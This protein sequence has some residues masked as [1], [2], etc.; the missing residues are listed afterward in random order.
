[1]TKCFDSSNL[2]P[3]PKYEHR[4]EYKIMMCLFLRLKIAWNNAYVSNIYNRQKIKLVKTWTFYQ[5][6][7]VAFEMK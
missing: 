4:L 1:M 3:R 6:Q 2:F 7:L 5:T